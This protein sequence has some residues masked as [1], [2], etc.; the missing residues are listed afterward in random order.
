MPRRDKDSIQKIL[1]WLSSN[2]ATAIGS[3]GEY[4]K[5]RE[6]FRQLPPELA[7]LD[8]AKTRIVGSL[9]AVIS[10]HETIVKVFTETI[11][12]LKEMI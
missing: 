11:A 7:K 12:S 2:N 6:S 10:H 1:D 4:N 3:L 9:G 8:A 5:I